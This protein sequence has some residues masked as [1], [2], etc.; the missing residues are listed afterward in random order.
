MAEGDGDDLFGRGQSRANGADP[1][2][3]GSPDQL[4]L[5]GGEDLK[6]ALGDE[7][8][9]DVA[10]VGCDL[11]ADG[12]AVVIRF[13]VQVLCNGPRSLRAMCSRYFPAGFSDFFQYWVTMLVRLL[14]GW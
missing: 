4:G 3:E 8:E 14:L 13:V 5:R 6:E 10:M 2:A 12:V 9:L 1:G 7:S 11:S